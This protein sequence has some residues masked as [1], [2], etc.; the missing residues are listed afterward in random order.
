MCLNLIWAFQSIVG[1]PR[2]AAVEHPFGRPFGDVGDTET[3]REVLRAALRVAE[4]AREPGSVVQLPFVWPLPPKQTKWFPPE[5]API[6]RFMKERA[7]EGGT[8]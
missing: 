1:M 7:A 4:T 8:G 2:V 5:P 6:I 3:Q